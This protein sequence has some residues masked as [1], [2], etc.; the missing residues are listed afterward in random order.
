MVTV[1]TDK[2]DLPVGAGPTQQLL[3]T[4]HASRA[5][6][7]STQVLQNSNTSIDNQITAQQAAL[8]ANAT[9]LKALR[10]VANF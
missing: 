7:D 9:A 8:L 4:Q 3:V 10:P 5:L 6:L 1:T 2:A